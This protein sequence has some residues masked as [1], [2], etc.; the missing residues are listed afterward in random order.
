LGCSKNWHLEAKREK[1]DIGSTGF[2]LRV[3][4]STRRKEGLPPL[5]SLNP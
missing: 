2:V 5:F 4:I 1:G 3:P